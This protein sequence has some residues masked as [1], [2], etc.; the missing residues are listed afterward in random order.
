MLLIRILFLAVLWHHQNKSENIKTF[1][2]ESVR[3]PQG[4]PHERETAQQ[5]AS[6]SALNP[7]RATQRE[8]VR[9]CGVQCVGRSFEIHRARFT[10]LS[11][12]EL[13]YHKNYIPVLKFVY[14][15][16]GSYTVSH[17]SPSQW[18]SR[19]SQVDRIQQLFWE[20]N[21]TSESRRHRAVKTQES[22][23]LRKKKF[24][25]SHR[26]C[27]VLF[28]YFTQHSYP[29]YRLQSVRYA[30]T[31]KQQQRES[32]HR[33][34]G[35]SVRWEKKKTT[36]VLFMLCAYSPLR[37]ISYGANNSNIAVYVPG[38]KYTNSS[39]YLVHYCCTNNEQRNEDPA[40]AARP[41]NTFFP[42]FY[43][44]VSLLLSKIFYF[45]TLLPKER[46][47]ATSR[48]TGTPQS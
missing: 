6:S 34:Y 2:V 11:A 29:W 40:T 19:W 36:A 22:S 41:P 15:P 3:R 33:Q 17:L 27:L 18:C 45:L 31:W 42:G 16:T 5:C 48:L 28:A 37:A 25:L 43:P 21:K 1:P 46:Y 23:Q 14:S 30:W 35:Q 24:C 20:W 32:F 39:V 10:M 4:T 44:T 13:I 12:V 47:N 7:L 8:S 38:A 9:V 26:C